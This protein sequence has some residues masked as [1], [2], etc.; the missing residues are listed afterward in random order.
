VTTSSRASGLAD[1][2]MRV[3]TE[4]LRREHPIAELVA[5]YGIALRRVGAALVGRCPFHQDRGRPNLHVYGSGRW[6]C[7]RC[8]QRGDVIGFV[9][10]IENLTFRE[11]AARLDGPLARARPRRRGPARPL[12]APTCEPE[13]VWRRDEYRVLAAATD[14][15]ANRLLSD[16]VALGYMAGRG[17]PP[18]LLERYRV[19][20]ASGGELIPYLRWRR[21]PLGAAVRT[22]LIT[23]DGREFLDGRI[24]FPELR[25]GQPVWLIGRA[26]P[27]PDRRASVPG[28]TYL[29]LPGCKP[30]LGW[31]QAIR[32]TR[33]VCVLEGPMDLMALR[34]WGVPGLALCGAGASPATLELLRRWERLY[35]VL[36]NDTAGQEGTARLVE[37]LGSRVIP[38]ALPHGV[39]DPGDLAPLPDGEALFC[40]AIREAV[41]RSVMRQAPNSSMTNARPAIAAA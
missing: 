39:N 23:D 40:A 3:D 7:Y 29:G 12:P 25:D 9:Q 18:K 2:Q 28:P 37:T 21:L 26:L 32:D 19:G 4:A 16:E 8:D 22:G 31:D 14:L 10:Q 35:A 38:V 34:K 5:S 33:G 20:Y 27:A 13:F 36:D 30:L 24:V 41:A 1:T 15:Y 6:I 11:A 17:F